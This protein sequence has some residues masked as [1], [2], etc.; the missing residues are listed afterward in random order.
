MELSQIVLHALGK[1][2]YVDVMSP[3]ITKFMETKNKIE[4]FYLLDITSYSLLK[5][6]RRF[7][8]THRSHLQ[9]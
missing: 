5:V 8:G 3:N 4:E 6:S 1:I 9:D 7:G 2:V